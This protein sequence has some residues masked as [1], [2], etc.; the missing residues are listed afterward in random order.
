MWNSLIKTEGL[1]EKYEHDNITYALSKYILGEKLGWLGSNIH[2]FEKSPNNTS[3]SFSTLIS[4]CKA[5]E[6]VL[7]DGIG[8]GD[9]RI[10]FG[11][12][13]PI[14]ILDGQLISTEIVKDN[15]EIEEIDFMG[16]GYNRW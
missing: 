7:K 9:D 11:I 6:D 14:I 8:F 16:T 10:C 15:I 4:V 12:V 5:A 1:E 13:K 2:E 3:R